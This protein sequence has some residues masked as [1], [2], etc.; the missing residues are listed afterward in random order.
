MFPQ[1]AKPNESLVTQDSGRHQDQVAI[2]KHRKLLF[3][4]IGFGD[5]WAGFL[6]GCTQTDKYKDHAGK[7]QEHTYPLHWTTLKKML[8][9]GLSHDEVFKRAVKGL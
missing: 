6:V 1:V 9:S 5:D 4:E 3:T 7:M 8:D 2:D